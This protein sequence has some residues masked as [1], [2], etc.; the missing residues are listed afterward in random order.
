[1]EVMTVK[2]L[3]KKLQKYKGDRSL[4]CSTGTRLAGD[5]AAGRVIDETG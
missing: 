2:M 4:R 1:M 3:I 5:L